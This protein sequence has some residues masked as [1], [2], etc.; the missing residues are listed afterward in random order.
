MA[1]WSERALA[2]TWRPITPEELAIATP[3]VQADAGVEVLFREMTFDGSDPEQTELKTYVRLKVFDERG[4]KALDKMSV[5]YNSRSSR[6]AQV[7]ARVIKPNGSIIDVDRKSFF[8]RDVLRNRYLRVKAMSFSFAG[9]EPGV[10]AEYQFTERI[11]TIGGLL[12]PFQDEY[13]TRLVRLRVRPFAYPELKMQTIFFGFREMPLKDDRD[14]FFLAERQNVPA[15]VREPFAPPDDQVRPWM[16]FY[17][18][19]ENVKSEKYWQE[20]GRDL[21]KDNE[22][23]FRPR[24]EIKQAS[25]GIVAGAADDGEKLERIDAFCRVQISNL[26]SDKSGYTP[27]QIEKLKKNG[28]PADTLANR[29]GWPGDIR[30]LCIALARAAGFDARLALCSDRSRLRYDAMVT[31]R[32]VMPDQI[33]AV[34]AGAEWRFFQPDVPYVETGLLHWT[35]EGQSALVSDAKAPVYAATPFSAKERNTEKRTAKLQLTEDGTLE[36]DVEIV[37]SGHVAQR[38]KQEWDAQAEGD[39]AQGIIDE[40]HERLSAAE[41]TKI[42]VDGAAARTGPL[43]IRYHLRVPDYA[44]RTGQRLFIQPNIFEKGSAAVFTAETRKQPLFF[45]FA[46]VE[47]DHVEIE[48]PADYALENAHVPEPFPGGENVIYE[49]RI[50]FRPRAHVLVYDRK[51]AL[52]LRGVA[53]E[54]YAV[55]KK[56]FDYVQVNDQHTLTLR[57]AAPAPAPESSSVPAPAP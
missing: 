33:V 55:V 47:Q 4:V 15:I 25:A 2:A 34:K 51:F 5:E 49:P 8:T 40:V 53:V 45:P 57:R 54:H 16:L 36:G 7:A 35:N 28:G 14:G 48:V 29:Y 50:A 42:D 26:A 27:D 37:L 20:A 11:D 24:P 3:T 17:F 38:R 12:F 32:M 9:L 6:L 10:I 1:T 56:A 39:R 31:A 13:P 18:T 43:T 52:G 30:L 21:F 19:L 41:L 23:F 44:E 22:K 46:R